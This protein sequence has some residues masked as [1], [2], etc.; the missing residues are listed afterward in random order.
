[1]LGDSIVKDI[2]PFK[3][4]SMMEKNDRLY[5]KCFPGATVNDMIDY[6]K[7]S[8][9]HK[10]DIIV[11]HAG[12][13]NLNTED[14]P[15]V[16]ANN[17]IQQANEMKTD[18]NEIFISSLI[19]RSD[20]LNE[21]GMKVNDFL[22]IKSSEYGLRYIDNSNVIKKHLNKSGIHLNFTGTVTLAK[23]FMEAIKI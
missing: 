4:K 21:K 11:Y 9:R 3:M 1:M 2:K 20:I 22:Q 17:I 19:V 16:I 8:L 10:P 14:E 23:N 6:S 5:V 7:P 18:T 15:K 13:N 12:T